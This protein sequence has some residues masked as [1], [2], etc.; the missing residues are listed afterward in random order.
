MCLAC[1][2]P[3][4]TTDH[5][6]ASQSIVGAWVESNPINELEEQG[7]E[8]KV[9]GSAASINMATLLY[10]SWSSAGDSLML[11]V[12]SIGNRTA[13]TDTVVYRIVRCDQDSLLLENGAQSLRMARK[14]Q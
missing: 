3:T 5:E 2:K 7:F 4:H 10:Q 13:S 12:K 8:L 6:N 11:V 9:D 14:K 1:S